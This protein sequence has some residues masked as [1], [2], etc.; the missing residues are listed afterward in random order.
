MPT[1]LDMLRQV[2][3]ILLQRQQ[4]QQ[5][6]TPAAGG[7]APPGA[8]GTPDPA[9]LQAALAANPA[10]AALSPANVAGVSTNQAP[11][12]AVAGG[13]N[14]MGASALTA[15]GPLIRQLGGDSGGP[16][17]RPERYV[18]GSPTPPQGNVTNPAMQPAF[19]NMRSPVQ[20]VGAF[21]LSPQGKAIMSAIQ[22]LGR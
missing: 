8:G 12:P 2:L 6:V 5:G 22:N 4:A 21:L 19:Q 14:P 17:V 10:T 13:M 1:L 18:K 16:D 15:L 11:P 20:S 9:A 7:F 3:P